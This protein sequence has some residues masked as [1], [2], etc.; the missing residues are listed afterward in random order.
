[1]ARSWT[2]IWPWTGYLSKLKFCYHHYDYVPEDQGRDQLTTGSR[3]R[4][5]WI[6]NKCI[7]KREARSS[8][9]AKKRPWAEKSSLFMARYFRG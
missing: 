6:C 1:M 4:L 8:T 7:T 9:G 2:C 3:K 5:I